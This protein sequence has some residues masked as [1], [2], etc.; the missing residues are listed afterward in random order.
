MDWTVLLDKDAMVEYFMNK[1]KTIKATVNNNKS[2]NDFWLIRVNEHS[3]LIG[4]ESC[5][6]YRLV[7]IFTYICCFISRLT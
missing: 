5:S 6:K 1:S 2:E 7:K 4:I 3:D